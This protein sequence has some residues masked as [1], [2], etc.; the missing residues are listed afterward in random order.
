MSQYRANR[1][2][3]QR[4]IAQAHHLSHWHSS[5]ATLHSMLT[6]EHNESRQEQKSARLQQCRAAA[7]SLLCHIETQRTQ[8]MYCVCSGIKSW[9]KGSS[10]AANSASSDQEA[11]L[12]AAMPSFRWNK[13]TVA[14]LGLRTCHA[15]IPASGNLYSYGEQPF[16]LTTREQTDT[17]KSTEQPKEFGL[18]LTRS[19]NNAM[20]T[21]MCIISECTTA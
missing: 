13:T 12:N 7:G 8:C 5:A 9:G 10:L 4:P 14:I 15:M 11:A 1:S 2:Q 19:V 17:L 21:L 20:C 6:C 16:L 3:R 18:Q